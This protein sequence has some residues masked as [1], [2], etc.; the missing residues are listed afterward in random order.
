MRQ[1]AVTAVTTV[2]KIR[3]YLVER[4][5]R[6]TDHEFNFG[7][8]DDEW[9]TEDHSVTAPVTRHS[10]R[11]I[12]EQA[13]THG[14]AENAIG[15]F[16]LRRERNAIGFVMDKLDAPEESGTADVSHHR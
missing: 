2:L 6:R 10:A 4:I 5:A 11:R 8:A 7:V 13:A 14:S 12:K 15:D 3:A 16:L 9:R 1:D